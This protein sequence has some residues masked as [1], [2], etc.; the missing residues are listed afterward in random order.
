MA[1]MTDSQVG[2]GVGQGRR[3]PSSKVREPRFRSVLWCLVAFAVD[4]GL[5]VW[6]GV[7]QSAENSLIAGETAR[8]RIFGW[9]EWVPP[10]TRETLV[11]ALGLALILTVTLVRRCWR[12][13]VAAVGIV[14]VTVAATEAL[15]AVLPRPGLSPVPPGLAGASFPSG[16]TA[17]VAGLAL[18]VA[19]VSSARTRSYVAA[20]G[21]VW[22]AVIAGALQAL[23]WHRPSDVLGATLVACACY[24]AASAL[25]HPVRV[26]RSRS[27]P[28]LAL[29]AV[30][31]LLASSRED[32]LVRPLV[33]SGVALVCSAL[34]WF[35]ATGMPV[36]LTRTSR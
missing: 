25:L 9:K 16:T 13:G 29:A 6:T 27:L 18:G 30:G 22:L 1:S 26:G 20:A 17:I 33:F 21:A 3:A 23:S 8:A 15:H 12:E 34:L 4:Y 32:S 14:V 28:P 24:G 36:G 35:T 19:T 2:D 7:G 31:A 10:L 11:L 5:A